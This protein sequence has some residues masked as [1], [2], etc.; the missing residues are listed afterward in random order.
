KAP[1]GIARK[2]P[3]PAWPW[4]GLP[5][6]KTSPEATDSLQPAAGEGVGAA[7]AR[8]VALAVGV[9]V[10]APLEPLPPAEQP[11]ST[12]TPASVRNPGLTPVT[13]QS[14]TC[15]SRASRSPRSRSGARRPPPWP[16]PHSRSRAP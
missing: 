10:A 11:A 4:T 13:P 14:A 5:S 9:G 6:V 3:L 15:S 7:V 1:L 8:V 16:R 2:P 12:R